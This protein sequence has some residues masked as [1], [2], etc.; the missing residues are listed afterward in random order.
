M[1]RGASIQSFA[2]AAVS[3]SAACAAVLHSAPGPVQE[4]RTVPVREARAFYIAAAENEVLTRKRAE[5]RFRGSPWS[6]DDEFHNKEA[7][8]IRNYGK[9][10][11]LSVAALVDAEG[12]GMHEGWPTPAGAVPE[13]KVLPC[14]PRLT[15]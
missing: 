10:H 5:G 14:R 11:R 13:Q 15:Y 8:F 7:K 12:R 6:Q 3:L 9:S 2:G 4:F 1:L